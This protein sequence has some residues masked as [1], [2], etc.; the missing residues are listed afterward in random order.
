MSKTTLIKATGIDRYYGNSHAVK[1][2]DLELNVGDILGFLGPNGAGKSTT[3]QIIS[4]TL[5]PDAGQ[6]MINGF[7]LVEQPTLAKQQLGYLPEQ[8][9]LYKELTVN[10]YLHYCAQLRNINKDSILSA[11][12]TAKQRCGLSDVGQ[13]LIN[14]LSKGFQQRVGIAQAIIH[15]PAVIILDEPTVGL[16][17]I[18]IQEI[19]QL[20]IELGQH[21][22]I[23]LSTHILPEVQAVCNRVQI[24][25]Q[26]QLVFNSD[27]SSIEA[28]HHNQQ[29]ELQFKHNADASLL[30]NIAGILG[31]E[32]ISE[33]LFSIQLCED[34]DD[35]ARAINSLLT[36]VIQQNWGLV[37]FSPGVRSLEQIF[38]E[39]TTSDSNNSDQSDA[40]LT[41]KETAA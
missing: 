40:G 13:Q 3:M 5:A 19:R 17:P 29:L 22:G 31:V 39:L 38:I 16:D 10:E 21:H 14:S 28:S 25:R 36:T 6:I 34:E 8:P 32:K 11:L 37:R 24:I 4:G 35:A 12:D 2:L 20:I 15:N 18:Q 1:N 30:E 26:G 33:Q 9:P 23:I 27:M 7:D 41:A